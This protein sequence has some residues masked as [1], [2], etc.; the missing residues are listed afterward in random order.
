MEPTTSV[1]GKV[2]T[3]PTFAQRLRKVRFNDDISIKKVYNLKVNTI[4]NYIFIHHYLTF[5]VV[6]FSGTISEAE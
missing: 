1:A 4:E 6:Y 5:L 3:A 2:A